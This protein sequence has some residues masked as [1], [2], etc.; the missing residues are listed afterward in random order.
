MTNRN[1]A[2]PVLRVARTE[3]VA[4]GVLAL[5]LVDP[6]G[7]PLPSWTP[8]AH[9]DL[10]LAPGL[11]RPYS[12]CSDPGD[13]THYRVAVLRVPGGRGG[14]VHTHDR[15]RTG[16]TLPVSVPRNHFE[17]VDAERYLLVAGGIGITPL[18]PMAHRLTALGK[19]WRMLYG[20]RSRTTM[21]F[22]DELPPARVTV[23]PQ[24]ETGLPDLAGF[25]SPWPDATV[26]ACGPDGLLTAVRELHPGP[27]HTERFTP[28]VPSNPQDPSGGTSRGQSFTVRLSRSGLTLT[29]PADRSVLEVVREAGVSA[30]SS[31]EMGIC[32]SCETKVLEGVPDHRDDLLTPEEK[33]GGCTM[34][35]CVS[36]CLGDRLVLD[37]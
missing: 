2:P 7:A 4:D 36:R 28:P 35:I 33:T 24:D 32:G 16:D 5:T 10:H 12:L 37:L 17:L 11:I 34:M 8:G 25:L 13:P 6:G 22:L 15:V 9:V 19:P 20:G 26:Y 27:V 31:C 3:L 30:D 23:A 21:A 29:V 1:D 14:S 18:L